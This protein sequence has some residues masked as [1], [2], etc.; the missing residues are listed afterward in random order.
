MNRRYQPRVV[1]RLAV[2][3]DFDTV[4]AK[5]LTSIAND[6]LYSEIYSKQI[7]ALGQSGDVLLVMSGS[8]N[9]ENILKAIHAARE[10]GL[11]VIAMSGGDGGV[12]VELLADGDIH[13]GVPHDNAARIQEVYVLTL[14]CL[15]DSIDCLLL[16]VN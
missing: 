7:M 2:Q 14:H 9:S 8:G 1:C 13:I 5:L 4:D 15:C 11:R 10:R 3:G 6:D 16:G 12:L